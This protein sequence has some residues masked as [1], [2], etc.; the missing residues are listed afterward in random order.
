MSL[1]LAVAFVFGILATFYS[2]YNTA[3]RLASGQVEGAWSGTYWASAIAFFFGAAAI[4]AA[5]S[6]KREVIV[7]REKSLEEA[8][9][10]AA[11]GEQGSANQISLDNFR[12]ALTEADAA[13]TKLQAGL[14]NICKELE[15]GQGAAYLAAIENGVRKVVLSSGYALNIGESTVISYEYGEGLVGQA[16]SEGKA[17]YIDDVPEGYIKIISGLG[18]ASPRYLL[19]APML[20]GKEVAGV[21]ELATFTPLSQEQRKFVEDAASELSQ[22]LNNNE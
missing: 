15:V 16:A 13:T 10:D 22:S 6:Y 9:Q 17:L 12:K 2:Y 7:Y 19:I 20:R 8:N 5:I 4:Y 1:V 3:N 18:T 21:I 14:N 11:A